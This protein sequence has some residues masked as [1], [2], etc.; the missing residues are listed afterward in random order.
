M[1][2]KSA[3]ALAVGALFAAPAL[4]QITP[5]EVQIYGRMYPQFTSAKTDG[6]TTGTPPSNLVTGTGGNHKRRNSID[7]QNS[8]FGFRGREELG[9][10]MQAIWQIETRVRFDTGAGNVW[11]G[12]RNSYLGLRSGFGTVKL[13]NMDT[14]YKEY[15]GIVG[16][17]FGISS[18]NFV[19]SSNVLSA[20]GL[21]LEDSEFGDSGFHI[22]APNSIQYETPSFGGF[23]AGVQYSPDEFK[24]NPGRGDLN[25][26][27]WSFGVKYEAGPLYVSVQHE[28]HND[29]FDGSFNANVPGLNT[30]SRDQ[31]SRLSVGFSVTPAHRLTADLQRMEWKE[32]GSTVAGDFAKY[33]KNSWAVGWEARW[34]GPWRT[35]LT[36]V[37]SNE[38]DC[39]LTGGVACN[40]DGLE[41]K[42]WSAGVAYSL[43]K[44]T[45]VYGLANKLTAGPSARFDNAANFSPS[46]GADATQF[47]VGM[48]HSF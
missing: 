17:F 25:T 37:R 10:G 4:A 22:R 36:Y 38:G 41:G 8:R 44:R 46:R 2:K 13:G 3:V 6:A 21:D 26:D 34:G 47:A 14:I 24:G 28:R 23:T 20:I 31:A 12:N 7:T 48:S 45:L 11:A 40:T 1:N 18:G 39:S 30:D 15:G 35:E 29:W 42:M 16:N 19:S 32:S 5:S 27:L 43:S 33:K 9:G